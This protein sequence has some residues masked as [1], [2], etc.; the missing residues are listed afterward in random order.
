M[1]AAWT[2]HGGRRVWRN[3]P[4]DVSEHEVAHSRGCEDREERKHEQQDKGNVFVMNI[5]EWAGA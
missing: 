1:F 3:Y 4:E 5:L 2:W